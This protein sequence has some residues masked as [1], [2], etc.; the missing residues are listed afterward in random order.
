MSLED[1]RRGVNAEV[2]V[3][4]ESDPDCDDLSG[5][6]FFG[7]NC[8]FVSG[9]DGNIFEE[10][11]DRFESDWLSSGKVLRKKSSGKLSRSK[12]DGGF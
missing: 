12:S 9:D 11:F 1:E 6:E 3:R 5:V 10:S 7:G 8:Q 2:E 4:S